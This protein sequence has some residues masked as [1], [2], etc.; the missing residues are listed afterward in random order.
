MIS[1]WQKTRFLRH[2][3]HCAIKANQNAACLNL[4][5][6]QNSVSLTL[7]HGEK[8]RNRE[9]EFE[10]RAGEGIGIHGFGIF[11]DTGHM[12]NHRASQFARPVTLSLWQN[13]V[14]A[15]SHRMQ[16]S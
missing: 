9:V 2:S 11:F 16:V 8:H 7:R 1:K 12:M 10:F 5:Q 4:E 3:P 6:E 14:M 13:R 15:G